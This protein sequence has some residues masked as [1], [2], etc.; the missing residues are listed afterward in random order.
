M[1]ILALLAATIPAGTAQAYD[2]SICQ[3]G[4]WVDV[5]LG[6]VDITDLYTDESVMGTC[7]YPAPRGC[8]TYSSA[9]AAVY[10]RFGADDRPQTTSTYDWKWLTTGDAAYAPRR[11]Y[12]SHNG[13]WYDMGVGPGGDG[14]LFSFQHTMARITHP[15][16]ELR[17]W[18]GPSF[19]NDNDLNMCN[20]TNGDEVCNGATGDAIP[21][22]G[23]PVVPGSI[24]LW[25]HPWENIDVN[26]EFKNFFD[27]N[28]VCTFTDHLLMGPSFLNDIKGYEPDSFITRTYTNPKFDQSYTNKCEATYDISIES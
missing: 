5:H 17:G 8:G 22:S 9:Y 23:T 7:A 21:L 27:G 3:S 13:P 2:A 16:D 26:L 25:V 11:A 20:S 18:D 6:Y 4:C 24:R 14:G 19:W 1:S 28:E 15:G 12:N 10:G